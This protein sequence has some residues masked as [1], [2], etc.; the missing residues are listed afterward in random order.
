[1]AREDAQ[2]TLLNVVRFR[3]RENPAVASGAMERREGATGSLAPLASDRRP[4][5]PP[6][7]H[8]RIAIAGDFPRG[9]ASRYLSTRHWTLARWPGR[10]RAP[11]SPAGLPFE[12]A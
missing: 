10:K 1:M 6:Q 12:L 8:P 11:P 7:H 9:A 5:A 2:P 3:Q 4:L